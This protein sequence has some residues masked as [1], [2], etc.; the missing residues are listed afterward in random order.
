MS[1]PFRN[2]KASLLKSAA[3]IWMLFCTFV[4]TAFLLFYVG[5]M[6]IAWFTAQ[7]TADIKTI[8][9]CLDSGG[10]WNDDAQ[11]CVHAS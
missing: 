3:K 2:N 9:S 5:R 10:T 7:K 11:I 6:T 1:T 8:E 4:V